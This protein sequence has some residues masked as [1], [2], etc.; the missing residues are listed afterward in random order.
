M[1]EF[2]YALLWH[3][4]MH[5]DHG[6]RWIRQRMAEIISAQFGDSDGR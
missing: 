6:H 1:P 4:R 5:S 2:H 3:E